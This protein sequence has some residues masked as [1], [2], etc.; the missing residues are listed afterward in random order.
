MEGMMMPLG[1]LAE[2]S[3]MKKILLNE[4]GKISLSG[5]VDSQKVHMMAGLGE[6]F[7]Y[8]VIVT[9]SDLGFIG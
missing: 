4:K 1:E 6:R 9:F 7:K 2:F 8:K 5:C 3:Q